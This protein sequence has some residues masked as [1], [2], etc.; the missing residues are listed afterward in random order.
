M[1]RT[2]ISIYLLTLTGCTTTWS[3]VSGQNSNY[4]LQQ[5]HMK[6][7]LYATGATPMPSNRPTSYDANVNC[8]GSYCNVRVQESGMS[9]AGNAMANAFA[10]LA[11]SQRYEKCMNHMGWYE[12]D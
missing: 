10:A 2:L 5:D 7:D 11:R 8:I 4:K 6:C 9:A 3:H 12:D 1:R